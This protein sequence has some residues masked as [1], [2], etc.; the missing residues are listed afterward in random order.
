MVIF[1]Q[2]QA[3]NTF[4]L[5]DITMNLLYPILSLHIHPQFIITSKVLEIYH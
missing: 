3:F 5:Q 4:I 2:F 1:Q